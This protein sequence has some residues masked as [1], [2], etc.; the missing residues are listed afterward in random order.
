MY[1]QAKIYYP[2]ISL[3]LQFILKLYGQNQRPRMSN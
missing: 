3:T 2:Y 1:T